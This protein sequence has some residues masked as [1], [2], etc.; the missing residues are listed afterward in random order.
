MTSAQISHKLEA[1]IRL[2]NEVLYELVESGILCEIRQDDD[3]TVVYQPA[4][5]LET[6]TVRYVIDALENRGSDN[7]PVIKSEELDKISGCLEEFG[8]TIEKSSA[9]VLLRDI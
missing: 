2:V 8:K 1:P 9:N 7:I 6:L 4:K 5:D 3:K